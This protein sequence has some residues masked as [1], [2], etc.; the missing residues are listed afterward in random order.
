[1]VRKAAL[2]ILCLA[3]IVALAGPTT[4]SAEPGKARAVRRPELSRESDFEQ[5][6][7]F[8]RV[9]SPQRYAAFMAMTD[10]QKEKA[11]PAI[12]S[13]HHTFNWLTGDNANLRALKL[14][15][16]KLEDDIFGIK[17]RLDAVPEGLA[18]KKNEL[19]EELRRKVTELVEARIKERTDRIEHLEGLLK[20]EKVKLETDLKQ[21]DKLIESRYQEVLAANDLA[22]QHRPKAPNAERPPRPVRR[23][24]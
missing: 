11:R 23:D 17:K 13:R 5:A 18:N 15:Q 10:E 1:M 12:L 22:A 6:I 19:Q 8:F 2:M 21:K 4:R 24:R 16:V 3:P 9:H 20:V 7:E 14:R